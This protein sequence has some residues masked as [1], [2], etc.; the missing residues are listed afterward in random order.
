MTDL[1]LLFKSIRTAVVI[2]LSVFS[3]ISIITTGYS[4]Y[5]SFVAQKKFDVI[6]TF[7]NFITLPLKTN[8]IQYISV[9]G[10][11][12][13]NNEHSYV[14][15]YD[16]DLKKLVPFL[17]SCKVFNGLSIEECAKSDFN[18]INRSCICYVN[19]KLVDY[20]SFFFSSYLCGNCKIR[21]ALLFSEFSLDANSFN[22]LIPLIENADNITSPVNVSTWYGDLSNYS[23]KYFGFSCEESIEDANY[24]SNYNIIISNCTGSTNEAEILEK[25]KEL[26][27][28]FSKEFE[29]MIFQKSSFQKIDLICGPMGAKELL[30]FYDTCES[31]EEFLSKMLVFAIIS[32]GHDK[33][34]LRA[35]VPLTLERTKIVILE[36]LSS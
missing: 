9:M 34:Y 36:S 2:V 6:D 28:F 7:K 33:I 1:D 30:V 8:E 3:M 25:A 12:S 14:F 4:V 27:R 21:P 32:A 15:L 17:S 24:S 26:M 19:F 31:S 22:L 18:C 29:Y 35:F 13:H 16:V 10:L 5:I 11:G 20:A 23:F